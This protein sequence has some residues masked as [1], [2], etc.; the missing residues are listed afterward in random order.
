[1][2]MSIDS[3]DI[4]DDGIPE[5]ITGWSNGKVSLKFINQFKKINKN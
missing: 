5:L 3:Y 1:M 4:N 2:A